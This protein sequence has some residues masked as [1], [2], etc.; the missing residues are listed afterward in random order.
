MFG[1][2]VKASVGVAVEDGCAMRYVKHS[3]DSIS[4]VLGANSDGVD[5]LYS[6]ESLERFIELAREALDAGS[7]D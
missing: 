7:G 4:F 3:E 5:L 1:S 6:A 2:Q